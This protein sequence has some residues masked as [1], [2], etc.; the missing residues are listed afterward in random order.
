MSTVVLRQELDAARAEVTSAR[1][2]EEAGRLQLARLMDEQL[3]QN[4]T[5]DALR[6]QVE[7]S[8]NSAHQAQAL[9]RSNQDQQLQNARML[10]PTNYPSR[11]GGNIGSTPFI[12]PFSTPS[13]GLCTRE[14][15][16]PGYYHIGSP[17]DPGY[18]ESMRSM[19]GRDEIDP[20]S[21]AG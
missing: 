6:R 16:R 17:A 8:N 15:H 21:W 11:Q 7:S 14:L 10:P 9:L 20:V 2:S 19:Y 4:Q 12:P 13:T 1:A 3:V 5:I 18:A